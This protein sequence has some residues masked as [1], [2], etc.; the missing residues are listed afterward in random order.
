[1]DVDPLGLAGNGGVGN[2]SGLGTNSPYKHC[3][4]VLG[5]PNK[6]E[7]KVKST[8]KWVKKPKPADWDKYKNS[9]CEVN[10][11][12]EVKPEPLPVAPPAL[13]PQPQPPA[14]PA[15]DSEPMEPPSSSKKWWIAGGTVVGG[16][17]AILCVVFEPCG[18]AVVTGLGLTGLAFEMQR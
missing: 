3:R 8:G 12:P 15:V 4:E 6:I 7:C 5:E 1:M 18:A 10:S 17:A 9:K 16:G 13:P 14:H 11:A 2:S